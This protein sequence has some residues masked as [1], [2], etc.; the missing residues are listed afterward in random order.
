[1]IYLDRTNF[2]CSQR[3][4][5]NVQNG[6]NYEEGKSEN[7]TNDHHQKLPSSSSRGIR[8]PTRDQQC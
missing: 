8:V 2:H 1:M 3:K 6:G 4:L 7:V 5:T